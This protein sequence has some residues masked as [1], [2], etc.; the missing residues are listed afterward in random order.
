MRIR[1]S[2]TILII[3]GGIH[4]CFF[5]K[6]LLSLGA[7]NIILIEKNNELLNETS[8][9]THNRANMGYHYP[10]SIKTA[11]ECKKGNE[12]FQ[13]EFPKFFSKKNKSYYLIDKKSKTNF[14]TYL[15]FLNKMKLN[16]KIKFPHLKFVKHKRI[17]NSIITNEAVFNHEKIS[18]YLNNNLQKKITIIKNFNLNK[19]QI[20]KDHLL[21]ESLNN[22]KLKIYNCKKILNCT[23]HN[24]NKIIKIFDN[25][26]KLN[27]FTYQKTE[28]LIVKSKHKIPPL[29]YM[30]G[31]FSTIMPYANK[32]NLYL[33]YDVVNSI[34]QKNNG[35]LPKLNNK[36]KSNKTKIIKTLE[37]E[38]GYSA[39]RL[40]Y[41]GND[42]ND[43]KAIEL[44]GFSACPADSHRIIK[45]K[46]DL[47]LNTCGGKGV[48]RELLEDIFKI[49]F[50]DVLYI[51]NI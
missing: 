30:D 50:I 14:K 26:I 45:N 3:G 44:C 37:D 17:E 12:L 38:Y 1:K 5:G 22:K 25:K 20:K 43:Y 51:I 34:I 8:F 15:S 19:I 40:L 33:I 47:T 29:T 13:K 39:D 49:D 7:K 31:N 23:Y 32:K 2:N 10:R 11:E 6:E 16:F 4:G 41:V 28:I 48:V 18:K 24:M 42:L 9:A 36:I 21:I 35:L 27:K 46:S